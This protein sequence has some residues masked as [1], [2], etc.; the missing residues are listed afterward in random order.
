MI[1]GCPQVYNIMCNKIESFVD[2]IK[3]YVKYWPRT[4]D[5]QYFIT[6]PCGTMLSDTPIFGC[7]LITLK[8]L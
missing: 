8:V 1:E 5:V 3:G 6:N 2:D 7:I 4:T